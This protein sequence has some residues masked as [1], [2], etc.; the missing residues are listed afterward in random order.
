MKPLAGA[1]GL[2]GLLAVPL[3]GQ[4]YVPPGGV[5]P[6]KG[7][8]PVRMTTVP[9]SG[10]AV[11][12]GQIVDAATGRGVSHAIVHLEGQGTEIT[13]LADT[14]GRFY[15]VGLGGGDYSIN[16]TKTGYFDGAYGQRRPGGEGLPLSML[17]HQWVSDLKI[18]LWRPAVIGGTV[19]DEAGEPLIGVRVEALRKQ[20]DGGAQQLVPWMSDVT[21]DQGEYRLP[22]LLA[23]DYVISVPSQIASL[24]AFDASQFAASVLA[25][26]DS[27]SPVS[28]AQTAALIDSFYRAGNIRL[29]PTGSQ[30][31]VPGY[32]NPPSPTENSTAVM[33]P[34][35]YYGGTSLGSH[36]LV[37]TVASG[38][39]RSGANLQ[40][41]PVPRGAISGTV[42]GPRGPVSNQ[43]LRL[44]VAGDPDLGPGHESAVTESTSEGVFSFPT[45]PQGE[46]VIEAPSNSNLRI[47][48]AT[49]RQAQPDELVV[50]GPIGI[51]VVSQDDDSSDT[52]TPLWGRAHVTLADRDVTGVQIDMQPAVIVS[53]HVIFESASAKPPENL[54][55]HVAFDA[56]PVG[57][58]AGSSRHA[59]VGDDGAF[60]I[61]GLARGEYF[62]RPGAPPPGWYIKAVMSAGHDLLSWP[63][64]LTSIG[65]VDDLE[66]IYTDKPT[67]IGGVVYNAVRAPVPG[68]TIVIF[69][70]ESSYRGTAGQHPD[71]VRATRAT[72]AGGFHIVALPA[73][74]YYIAAI[75][76]SLADAW[77]DPRRLDVIRAGAKRMTLKAGDHVPIDLQLITRR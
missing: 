5:M 40:L 12:I 13:R 22:K 7:M 61:R 54:S 24:P 25:S 37:I 72:N 59:K 60:E 4:V 55:Q 9:Y 70:A 35:T 53:G 39:T 41:R 76:E 27:S 19:T 17:E 65:D 1:I 33:Y 42:V 3:L 48:F 14:S 32:L 58:L 8:S 66:V 6:M 30:A 34:T 52:K 64:D 20:Y 15:V 10:P 77:Q 50:T 68:A 43:P 51:S 31:L 62:I 69:P 57:A 44:L 18:A 45:V 26:P 29:D 73:G 16:A 11:V 21:D 49:N 74:D 56:T 67:E 36:A 47:S 28:E 23:G 38:E 71:R 63:L 75:D 46:Y 2:F